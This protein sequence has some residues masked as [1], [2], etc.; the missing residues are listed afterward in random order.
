[1]PGRGGRPAPLLPPVCAANTSTS[2]F[3]GSQRPERT[4]SAKSVTWV[5]SA[6]GAAGAVQLAW[7]SSRASRRAAHAAADATRRRCAR[8]L[9]V[10]RSLPRERRRDRR[11]ASR[12]DSRR[13]DL[14]RLQP[15]AAS[16]ANRKREYWILQHSHGSW[17]SPLAPLRLQ[18]AF[19]VGVALGGG[20]SRWTIARTL[21]L[22][23]IRAA[24]PPRS[25]APY[26]SRAR[27]PR[28]AR[29]INI[30]FINWKTHPG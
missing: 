3:A 17:C 22:P 1:M 24:R 18:Q 7:C 8:K 27:T 19:R 9:G 15:V 23:A 14:L 16:K 2:G 28:P 26:Q 30:A 25:G 5:S 29:R 13:R 4:G 21:S 20:F 10:E 11:H 12:E 6:S